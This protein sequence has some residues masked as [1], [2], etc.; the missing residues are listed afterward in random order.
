MIKFIERVFGCCFHDWQVCEVW[1]K[2]YE[3]QYGEEVYLPTKIKRCIKCNKI[4]KY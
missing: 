4:I 1:T 2:R 3:N